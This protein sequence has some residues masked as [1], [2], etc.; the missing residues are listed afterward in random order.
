MENEMGFTR[1]LSSFMVRTNFE[2]LPDQS[3]ELSK[4]NI[5]DYIG[6]SLA[7]VKTRVSEIICDFVRE[8]SSSNLSGIIGGHMKSSPCM[9]AFANGTIAH[10][11]DYDDFSL[12]MMA[13]PSVS[14]LPAILAVGETQGAPG[15]KIIEA[16]VL[17]YET[18]AKLGV[19][20]NPEH[21]ELGWH[22][23]ATLGT[24]GA[25]AGVSKLLRLTE[26]Q[27]AMAFGI[28]S[29]LASGLTKNFGTMTK[30]L[31]AGNSAKN[32]II[33]ASL[34]Q[35][36][37][38][39]NNNVFEGPKGA[40]D[41]L[42]DKKVLNLDIIVAGLGNP[43]DIVNP[44]T[45]MKPYP[46]CAHGH[47]AIDAL[48][49]LIKRHNLSEE[50]VD[51]VECGV[52]YR[53]PELMFYTKPKTGFEGKFSLEYCLAIAI[54]DKKVGLDQFADER[55]NEDHLQNMLNR[56]KVYVHPE[57]RT[58]ESYKNRFAEVTIY[59]KKG[60]VYTKRV[61]T[62]LGNPQNPLTD[63]DLEQKFKD[64]TK[65]ILPD[66]KVN[67]VIKLVQNLEKLKNIK[68]LMDIIVFTSA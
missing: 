55:I 68:E 37:F 18:E 33:A 52:N 65:S 3:I 14:I 20:L 45:S 43:F 21:Y 39:A 31:H 29:S 41:I 30:P 51:I 53:V 64:C 22:S 7:G 1:A 24:F 23:T 25:L 59:T 9:A 56:I 44:G 49:S 15:D 40:F 62:P 47:A 17:G 63:T 16:Y 26:E 13:H 4:K 35:K 36:G 5:L 8:N 57:L 67:Q 28:A 12:T 48:L 50:S 19:C 58:K 38:T 60:D 27:I 66:D 32:G 46:S 2:M 54:L 34:A 11:L 10:A 6:V 42:S 61:Y